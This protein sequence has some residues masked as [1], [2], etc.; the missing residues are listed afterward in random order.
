VELADAARALL[1]A[2]FDLGGLA[3]VHDDAEIAR[4]FEQVRVRLRSVAEELE[5]LSPGA[6][7]RM[8]AAVAAAVA[9]A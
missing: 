5:R 8:R 6:E 7:E 2:S 9:A 3:D 1:E 4:T